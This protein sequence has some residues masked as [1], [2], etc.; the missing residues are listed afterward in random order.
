VNRLDTPRVVEPQILLFR[1]ALGALPLLKA[2]PAGTAFVAALLILATFGLTWQH[3]SSLLFLID[4]EKMPE[5]AC[6]QIARQ[7]IQAR[8]KSGDAPARKIKVYDITAGSFPTDNTSL[9]P[10]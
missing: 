2:A 1:L 4:N 6:P 8:E 10:F 5:R 7:S 3:F 9:T